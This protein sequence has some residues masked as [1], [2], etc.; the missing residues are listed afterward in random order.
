MN[1]TKD[2]TI[3]KILYLFVPGLLGWGVGSVFLFMELNLWVKGIMLLGITPFVIG[4][5]SRVDKKS[6]FDDNFINGDRVRKW[7]YIWNAGLF[8][9]MVAHVGGEPGQ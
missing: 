2:S 9:L 7:V 3:D 5:L 4:C 6:Y 8:M 1:E